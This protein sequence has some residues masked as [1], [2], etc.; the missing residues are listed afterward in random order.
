MRTSVPTISS[1]PTT[2]PSLL[3]RVG[4]LIAKLELMLQV[5][6]ERHALRALDDR[7]LKDIGLDRGQ[8]EIESSRSWLDLP[9]GR[10]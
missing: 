2:G 6:R 9:A 4:R 1:I 7:M 3:V 8:V 10:E 5:Q